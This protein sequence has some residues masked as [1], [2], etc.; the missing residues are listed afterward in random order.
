[1]QD[2]WSVGVLVY[3]LL[4]GFPPVVLDSHGTGVR[5]GD[6]SRRPGYSPSHLT[7]SFPA[8]VSTSARDFIVSALAQQPEERPT[9]RQLRCHPWVLAMG[10]AGDV[11]RQLRDI[12]L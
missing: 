6:G 5:A 2:I 1:M 7:L 9:V 3:E 11:S 4:V 8:S 12:E 10:A